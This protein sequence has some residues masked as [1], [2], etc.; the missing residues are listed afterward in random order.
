[1]NK[2]QIQHLV[3]AFLAWP[4]PPSV[5]SDDCATVQGY[6]SR[7]GTNLLTA[8]EARQM[9]EHV[10]RILPNHPRQAAKPGK[11]FIAE[12]RMLRDQEWFDDD[13]SGLPENPREAYIDGWNNALDSL[14]AM[15]APDAPP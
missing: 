5:R 2:V 8:D 11:D 7:I 4:L 1:M 14:L 3:D 9:F 15:V 6:P 10:L 13:W 12:A